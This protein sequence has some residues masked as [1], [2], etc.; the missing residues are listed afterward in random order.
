MKRDRTPFNYTCV[1]CLLGVERSNAEPY[2]SEA[3]PSNSGA[4]TANTETIP[5]NHRSVPANSEAVPANA[6]AVPKISEAE[7]SARL[8]KKPMLR[9]KQRMRKARKEEAQDYVNRQNL[10]LGVGPVKFSIL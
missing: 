1:D 4:V 2:Y 10:H 7:P 6:E 3:V 9:L 8:P 5:S